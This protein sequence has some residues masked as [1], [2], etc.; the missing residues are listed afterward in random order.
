M[1]LMILENRRL[2]TTLQAGPGTVSIGSSPECG[3]HLPD[4][5]LSAHQAS[6]TQ[7][8]DGVWWLEIVDPT[9]PTCL[10]RA[11]QK[12]RAKL[13]HADEIEMGEFAIRLF[14]ESKKTQDEVHRE[15]MQ[16]L[17]R[18]HGE[19]MPL[20]TITHKSEELVS[21]S[22]EQLEQITI[23]ALKLEQ[24]ESIPDA[25]PP[26]I[27]AILRTFDGRRAWVGL[28][29]KD[30]GPFDW[31]LA[32]ASNGQPCDRPAFSQT[33]ESRCLQH[34]Q[35]LCVPDAPPLEVRSAMAVPLTCASGN[36]G[37]LYVENDPDDPAYSEAQ[38]HVF[39]A[40][41]CAVGMPIEN[42]MRKVSAKRRA[43][44]VTEHAVARSTQDALTPKALP[45]WDNLLLA[46]YRH[47][48][49]ARCCDFY[50]V[51]QLRDRTAAIVLARITSQGEAIS[52]CFAQVRAA[53]RTSALYSE[54]PH[55]F[56]RA[57]NWVVF[58]GTP[59]HSIDLACAWIAPAAGKVQYCTAGP[60]IRLGRIR[61]DG[62]CEMI[63]PSELPPIG[64]TRAPA[65]APQALELASGD[66]L[67]M[68]TEGVTKATN[69]DKQV[70]GWAGLKENLC[71][72]LGGT[73]SN[74]L[75]EFAEDLTEFLQGGA[76][77]DDLTIVLAQRT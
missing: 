9:I 32:L 49:S 55:L 58:D 5:R 28:R 76:C 54:P 72:G 31:S 53:F 46:A 35:H 66:S 14:M 38:L 44:V 12:T 4:P 47:M 33:M 56:A 21:V 42:V 16:A 3:V 11:V 25:L 63:A 75:S 64:Q 10:N 30:E 67:V 48:G 39:S 22:K 2:R 34:T 73:P 74:V 70:L 23:L 43:V 8:D 15:R 71:D 40:L 17:A 59:N 57:L 37:M 77:P 61:A 7:D 65:L 50:D 29:R 45:Q 13:R 68:A 19:G 41:A 1:R 60:G 6:L 24:V 26:L 36:L 18:Q 69:A 52:R 20:G 62:T 51:V 27:R